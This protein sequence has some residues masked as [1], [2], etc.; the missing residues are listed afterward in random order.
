[1]E[2]FSCVNTFES[3][4]IYYLSLTLCCIGRAFLF[5]LHLVELIIFLNY[6]QKVFFDRLSLPKS[7]GIGFSVECN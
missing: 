6:S 2:K 4:Q 5:V 1:M 3:L 7:E